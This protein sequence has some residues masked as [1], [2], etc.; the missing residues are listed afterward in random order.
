MMPRMRVRQ[1]PDD[2]ILVKMQEITTLKKNM[3]I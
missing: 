1:H 2:E 3:H